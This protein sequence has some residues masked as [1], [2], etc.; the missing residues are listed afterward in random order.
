[1]RTRDDIFTE[2]LVRNNITTADTFITDSTL[3]NWIRDAHIW[4]SSFHKWPMTEGRA[5]TTFT[6]SEE[7]FIEGYKADSFRIMQIGGERLTKLNFEDY[8]TFREVEPT[9]DDRVY[10]S[11][12]KLVFINPYV[13]LT[14]TLTVY[15]QYQPY[16]DVTDETGTTIFTDWNDEGNEAIV[17]KMSSYLKRRLNNVQAAELHD[18]R[19]TAKLEEIWKRYLEEQYK[20]QT[21]PD[22]EGMFKRFDIL[23][24][25]MTDELIKRDQ[26]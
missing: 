23:H 20:K 8:Q 13:D 24:G 25:A 26:F 14:G 19:A 17:E 1:M 10:S 2:V 16:I 18:Q 6:G 5:S 11:F 7:W 22:S 21:H 15:G 9:A 3:K 12:G 4:A